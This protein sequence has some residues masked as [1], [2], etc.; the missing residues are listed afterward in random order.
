MN[1]K[2]WLETTLTV[3][4]GTG[5][6]GM[7]KIRPS[8]DGVYGDGVYF[9]DN[10]KD[11][12]A[13]AEPNGGVIQAEIDADDPAIKIV[14]KPVHLA[15]SNMVLRTHKVVVV[16]DPSKIKIIRYFD[17]FGRPKNE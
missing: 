4:R 17:E 12:L 3:Y 8:K 7:L 5:P 13:Y 1:F 14:E 16:P 15:G 9:Y 2:S 6:G 11:A 10:I